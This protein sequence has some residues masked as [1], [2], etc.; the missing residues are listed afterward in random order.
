MIEIKFRHA[1]G[2]SNFKQKN[3]CVCLYF[4]VIQ[5]HNC[6]IRTAVYVNLQISFA[7]FW[8]LTKR[9]CVGLHYIIQY[10]SYVLMPHCILQTFLVCF[11]P[12]NS[13]SMSALWASWVICLCT[14]MVYG[15]IPWYLH[16]KTTQST[17]INSYRLH[18]CAGLWI[19]TYVH[20]QRKEKE[21][22]SCVLWYITTGGIGKFPLL[23]SI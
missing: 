16:T 13:K 1:T 4:Y 20:I 5:S 2:F 3:T 9:Q 8:I 12:C 15:D 7:A 6:D 21:T 18:V 10:S 17:D 14:A 11:F 19:Y 23:I 22:S